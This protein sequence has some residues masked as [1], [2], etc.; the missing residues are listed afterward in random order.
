MR[1]QNLRVTAEQP[2]PDGLGRA[3]EA[4]LDPAV[5]RSVGVH[6]TPTDV[7]DRLVA[8]ALDGWGGDVASATVC[9]P[10][11]GGGAFLLA[12]A[13]ALAAAG[14]DPRHVVEHQLFGFEVDPVAVDVARE[15]LALWSGGADAGEHIVVADALRAY[16]GVDRRFDLVVGNPPFQGQL[17]RSTARSRARAADLA[18]DFGDA[19]R[20]YADTA[21]LFLV[22]ATRLAREGGR[23]ALIQPE[24]VLAARDAEGARNAVLDRA[25][26][27]GLWVAAE[28]V[29]DA[30]VRVCAPLLEVG[31]PQPPTVRLWRGRGLVAAGAGGAASWAHLAATVA[32]VPE[33]R[34]LDAGVLGDWC[35]ATAGFRQQFYGLAP[36]V[37]EDVGDGLPRVVTAGLVDPGACHWGRRPLRL[38]G[39][40]W[41][42][43]VVDPA[44]LDPELA[45]WFRALL[46]PKV[47]V[48]TQTRVVEA[49]A[50]LDGSLLPSVPVIAVVTEP[51][52][53]PFATAA[54]LAP[55]TSALLLR[56]HTGSALAS[57]ALKMSAR[58]V[59]GVPDPV[60][61][62]AWA[63]GAARAAELTRAGDEHTWRMR[64]LDLGRV[65]C[66]AYGEPDDGEVFTWWAARLPPWRR[67]ATWGGQG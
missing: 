41:H 65:M 19:A 37:R 45:G 40:T 62:A 10:A 14:A 59:L 49:V 34:P 36:H 9:D 20:G 39:T 67:E 56:R 2:T 8:L 58:Q 60:D 42:R 15:A 35:R 44:D 7:A 27:V 63:D 22:A 11:V 16:T 57:G 17:Q 55:P 3:Y 28:R 61:E 46:V 23:V 66:R 5:R 13:R 32:G 33:V 47:L 52:R 6:Y 12:A 24:S 64:L 1:A 48:A 18:R 25:A 50:D 4:T 29:F 51:E 54:L 30:E 38:A 21:A 26:L 43:P 53:V 31:A